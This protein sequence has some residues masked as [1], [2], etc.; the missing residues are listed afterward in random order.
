[1]KPTTLCSLYRGNYDVAE[2]SLVSPIDP[3]SGYSTYHSSEMPEIDPRAGQNVTRVNLTQL[4][5]AYDTVR[6]S[7]DFANVRDAMSKVQDLYGSDLNTYE[8]PLYFLKDVWLVSP[9]V[10]NF[11]GNPT[12]SGGEWNIGDWWVG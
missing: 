3:L 1:M 2:F 5:A 8:L 6:S 9:R 7:V 4:D 11:T 12:A 10:H